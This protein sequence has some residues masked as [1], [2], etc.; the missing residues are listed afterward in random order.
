MTCP[1]CGAPVEQCD[2]R[3]PLCRWLCDGWQHCHGLHHCRGDLT[4]ALAARPYAWIDISD[5]GPGWGDWREARD[6]EG[7]DPWVEAA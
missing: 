3:S 1:R 2:R 4:G 7:L 5:I 6:A